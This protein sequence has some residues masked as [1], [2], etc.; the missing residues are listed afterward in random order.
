MLGKTKIAITQGSRSIPNW[1]LWT[2]V[3]EVNTIYKG[4]V[5]FVL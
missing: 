5:E 1:I 2:Q 3:E 4:I